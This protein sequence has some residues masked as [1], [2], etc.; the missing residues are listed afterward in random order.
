MFTENVAKKLRACTGA[1]SLYLAL[2][3]VVLTGCGGTSAAEAGTAASATS[4]KSPST[5]AASVS[6]STATN[7]S[8]LISGSPATSA[9]VGS[10]YSFKPTASDPNGDV[11]VFAVVNKP[12]WA[13]FNT[14]TGALTGKPSSGGS[15]SGIVIKATDTSGASASLQAFTI[16]VVAASSGSATLS[17][18]KP[19]QNTD[20]S[21]MTNLAGYTI[22]YGTSSSNLDKSISI[23][24]PTTVNYTVSGLAAGVTYYFAIASMNSTGAESTRSTA[25]SAAI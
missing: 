10:T 22:Y 5:G 13:T 7:K 24:T 12:S 21:F 18:T 25:L 6:S 17:W 2:T 19:S 8:P 1:S 4:A 14:V 20:G 11:L 16:N 3:G 15:K 9:V 23:S